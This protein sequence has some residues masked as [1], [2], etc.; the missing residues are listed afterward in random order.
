L[1]D[2]GNF[3]PGEYLVPEGSSYGGL[4]DRFDVGDQRASQMD[5]SGVR[6]TARRLPFHV[7]SDRR[8]AFPPGLH[9]VLVASMGSPGPLSGAKCKPCR[10]VCVGL[11]VEAV[12]MG[13][14]AG[15]SWTEYRNGSLELCDASGGW[16]DGWERIFDKVAGKEAAS[17]LLFFFLFLISAT[18]GTRQ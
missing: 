4:N 12:G 15:W 8:Y 9:S 14:D 6:V 13:L 5:T 18:G 2:P 3:V 11:C 7:L 16:A 1:L 10:P 17:L